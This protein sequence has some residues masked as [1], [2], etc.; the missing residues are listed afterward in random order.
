MAYVLAILNQKGGAGKSTLATNLARAYQL[1]GLRVLLADADPQGTARNWRERGPEGLPPVVGA[2]HDRLNEDLQDV[3]AA[4]DLIIIDGAPRM[5]SRAV[6]SIKAADG[7]VIPV[8]PSAGDL[9]AT[10][11]I[12]ELV[13]TRREMTGRPAA[14]FV[15]SQAVTGS[16]L[17]AEADEALAGR[18]F[19]T[20]DARTMQRVAYQE[21]LG[22]GL[23]VLDYE[24]SG[25]AAAEIE[26]IADELSQLFD[27]EEE[28]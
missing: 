24:P 11:A 7:V 14:A 4:F 27:V 8:R 9:W 6:A 20:L 5:E 15:V 19:P 25:K 2:D 16:N 28:A 18:P 13:Q 10:D 26:A 3:G 23:S 22:A 17:A 21:A 12:V 1:K